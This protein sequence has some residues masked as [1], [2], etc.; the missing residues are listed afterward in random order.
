MKK[1]QLRQLIK[2]EIKMVTEKA[3]EL[4]KGYEI[5][6][7]GKNRYTFEYSEYGWEPSIRELQSIFKKI[8]KEWGDF[9]SKT[10]M[11]KAST[12]EPV[13]YVR[14][15]NV[16]LGLEFKTSDDLEQH[17]IMVYDRD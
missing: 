10:Q 17:G 9:V 1:S 15:G 14:H 6:R 16:T 5:Y 11:Q 3:M 12:K 4:P 7:L 13:V 8:Q 2:E